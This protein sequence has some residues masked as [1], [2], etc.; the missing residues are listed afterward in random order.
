ML[1]QMLAFPFLLYGQTDDIEHASNNS[2]LF[3]FSWLDQTQAFASNSAN[4]VAVQLDSF[5]GIPRSDLEA[6]YSSL[7]L[8]SINSW[9]ESSSQNSSIRLRGKLHLPRLNERLSLIFSEDGGD[10]SSYYSDQTLAKEQ[11]STRVNLQLNLRDA[12]RSRF[13]VRVG[14]RSSLKAHISAR[15]RYESALNDDLVNRLTETLYFTDSIGFGSRS[16]YQL[17]KPYGK[18]GL[19]RWTNDL[20][21]KEKVSGAEWSS[22]L[23]FSRKQSEQTA[24]SYYTRFTDS[25]NPE[26]GS[27]YDLGLR[28][29]KNISRPWLFL[30]IEPGYSWQNENSNLKRQGSAFIFISLEMAIGKLN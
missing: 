20:H 14:L 15:Y 5:F 11:Q 8:S 1:V 24:I 27:A 12:G 23:A 29:R 19:F 26:T 16:R 21:L 7:R 6:A 13:D 22:E 28:I 3:G 30:E 25:T 9:S 17:E 4:S 18:N 10:G 2:S